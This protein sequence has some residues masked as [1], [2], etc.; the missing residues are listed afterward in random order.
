MTAIFSFD[1]ADEQTPL[2]RRN[3]VSSINSFD[4]I[5]AH[6]TAR[7]PQDEPDRPHK[8]R[9]VALPS[10][11]T[12]IAEEDGAQAL[13]LRVGTP[14]IPIPQAKP[15]DRYIMHADTGLDMDEAWLASVLNRKMIPSDFEQVRVLGK[16]GYGTVLLVRHKATGQLFAQKQLKKASLIVQRKIV[17]M[18]TI[19]FAC[20]TEEYTKS[21]RTILEEVRNPFVVKLFYAFQDSNKLYLILEYAAGGE[22][23]HHLDTEKMFSED[24]AAFYLAQVFLGLTALHKQGIVYRDLKPENCLLDAEGHLLLTDFVFLSSVNLTQLGL[25]Q[26]R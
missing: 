1:E 24:V 14:P 25:K 19:S 15:A 9:H 7:A 6:N 21:E 22:L 10:V 17:G 8:T 2:S 5:W 11:Y 13:P 12:A 23:F 16:G 3:T 26:S 4:D 18:H 20:L